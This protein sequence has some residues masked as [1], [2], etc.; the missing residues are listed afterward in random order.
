M[1]VDVPHKF[2]RI[3]VVCCDNEPLKFL[4]H[5]DLKPAEKDSVSISYM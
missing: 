1:R 4:H 5:Y 3:L 2:M